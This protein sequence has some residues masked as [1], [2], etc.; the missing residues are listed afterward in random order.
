MDLLHVGASWLHEIAAVVLLGYY[1]LLALVFLP[2]LSRTV[3]GP[4]LGEAVETTERRAR[5]WLVAS[6]AVFLATGIYLLA[7]D[8]RF[9]GIGALSNGW[10]L[11][12][13]V[14]HGLVIAMLVL[15]AFMDWLLAPDVA[16]AETDAERARAFGRVQASAAGMTVLGAVVL[17]L[18]AAAQGS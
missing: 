1:G 2:A 12:I 7:T 18:T 11:L 3:E 4:A 6:V 9:T 5:P 16:L 17:L 13:L 10:S 8:L 15:G 14:K